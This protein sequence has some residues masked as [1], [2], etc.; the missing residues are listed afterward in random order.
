M[1]SNTN[2]I[3]KTAALSPDEIKDF[4]PLVGK[5]A[6]AAE[7]LLG[8]EDRVKLDELPKVNRPLTLKQAKQQFEL[9]Q[10]ARNKRAKNK[11]RSQ[12]FMAKYGM[13]YSEENLRKVKGTS[14]L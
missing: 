3:A 14:V 2:E 4:E 1:N 8:E 11:K 5:D 12:K 9:L 10:K 7:S 13:P 6:E